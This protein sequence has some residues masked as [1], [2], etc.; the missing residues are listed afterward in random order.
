[1]SG[2]GGRH[3]AAVDWA[4]AAGSSNGSDTIMVQKAAVLATD[5]TANCGLSCTKDTGA[6]DSRAS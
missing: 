4:A 3:T 6:A 1:M 5:A 2:P